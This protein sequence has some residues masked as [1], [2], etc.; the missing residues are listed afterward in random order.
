MKV[1]RLSALRTGRLYT[2]RN[3]L[4]NHF[5]SRLS[6][7]QGHSAAGRIMSMKNSHDTIWNRTR[8]LP[9]Y[10]AVPQPTAPPGVPYTVYTF[11]KIFRLLSPLMSAI[12]HL[13]QVLVIHLC[14]FL[15]HK[16]NFEI[17]LKLSIFA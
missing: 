8:D 9:G 2:S 5:C 13:F 6:R 17:P 16:C 15:I 11:I 7:P 12:P 1:V 14:M 4:D 10:S 3:I